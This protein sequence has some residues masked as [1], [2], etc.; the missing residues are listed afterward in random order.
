MTTLTTDR[1]ILR[2]W[3][4]SDYEPFARANADALVMEFM[5]A[6]LTRDESDRLADRIEDHFRERGLGLYAA[7]LRD[8]HSFIG[9]IGLAIPSFEAAFTPCVEIGWRL[10]AE[11]WRK[12]LATEGARAVVREAFDNL[13]IQELVSFTVPENFRSRRVMEKIGMTHNPADD[14]D[15]PSLPNG[16]P[17]RRHVLYRLSRTTAA[18]PNP[19]S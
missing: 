15:H 14:F 12:G 7:E 17:L 18:S 16:H 11:H 6:I 4:A 5:P 1:L 10:S 8:N 9:F 19:S 3:R 13:K 2:R